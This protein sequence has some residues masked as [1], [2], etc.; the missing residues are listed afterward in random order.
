MRNLL[1]IHQNFAARIKLARDIFSEFDDIVIAQSN[2]TDE[3]LNML[4]QKKFDLIIAGNYFSTMKGV[5]FYEKAKRAELNQATPFI[6]VLETQTQ[7]DSEELQIQ[8]IESLLVLPATPAEIRA[9]INSACNPRKLRSYDRFSLPNLKI[10]FLSKQGPLT[11][12]L[13]NISLSGML[14]DLADVSQSVNLMETTEISIEFPEQYGGKKINGIHCRLRNMTI[15]RW[16]EDFSQPACI[17]SGW[18]FVSMRS[19]SWSVLERVLSQ[20]S[21][22]TAPLAGGTNL[23]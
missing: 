19:S 6:L 12:E 18:E 17:R 10:T 5:D 23:D 3:G 13:L 15:L 14:C 11:A 22:E 21:K 20:V 2:S 9:K 1:L 7:N 4:N 16:Q 8:G